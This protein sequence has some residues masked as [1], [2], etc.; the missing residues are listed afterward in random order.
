MR[1][2]VSSS[3]SDEDSS[4][5]SQN[6]PPTPQKEGEKEGEDG[7]LKKQEMLVQYL[8]DTETFALQVERAI[9]VINSMLYWKTTSGRRQYSS[10]NQMCAFWH[11][12]WIY[13][14]KKNKYFHIWQ[15]K[16]LVLVVQ[17]AVQFCVTVCE[18]SVANSVSGVRK[19]LPLVWSTDAAIKDAVVQAYRRLYLNPQGDT[20]RSVKLL[21]T[22]MTIWRAECII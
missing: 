3:G 12:L 10:A 6:L 20:I 2:L 4:E 21:H 22:C 13:S 8:R 14:V 5:L 17:E 18:F 7:E 16:S 19:M 11:N 1:S 15:L 9:S